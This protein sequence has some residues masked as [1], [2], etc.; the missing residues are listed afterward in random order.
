MSVKQRRKLYGVRREFRR[1]R[2]WTRWYREGLFE[3]DP[4]GGVRLRT[5]LWGMPRP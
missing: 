4:Q 3:S 1:S 2:G 5:T